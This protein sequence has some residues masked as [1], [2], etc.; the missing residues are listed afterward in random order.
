MTA[1][2][3]R[4]RLP[5]VTLALGIAAIL[6]GTGCGD[7]EQDAVRTAIGEIRRAYLSEQYSRVCSRMT[8]AAQRE[9]GQL[10]HATPSNCPADIA[11]QMS[12]AILAPRDRIDPEIREID[13]DGDKATVTAIA[14]GNAPSTFY[15][16]KQDGAWK[17]N[18]LWGTTAPPPPD[19][20]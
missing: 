15:L 17:L 16:R 8:V 13:V 6:A 12:A 10:G 1:A 18:Q 11:K 2:S 3:A 7:G 9:V 14:G 5:F 19:L 4:R 20:Q